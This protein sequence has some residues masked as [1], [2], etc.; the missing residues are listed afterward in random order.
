MIKIKKH[1]GFSELGKRANN[2]DNYGYIEASTYVVCDGVG[3]AEKGEIA[4]EI[5]LKTFLNEYKLEKFSSAQDVVLKA[6]KKLLEYINENNG[7]KGM[8]TTLTFLIIRP[9]EV[10]VAWVGDSRIY[11]FRNGEIVFKTRDHSWVNEAIDAGIINSEEAI[12]HPK[13]NIITRAIQGE[14]NPV[15]VDDY[16][17]TDVRSGDFFLLCTDGV[18]EAWADEDLSALFTKTQNLDEIENALKSECSK[19]SRDNHTGIIIQIETGIE[20]SEFQIKNTNSETPPIVEAIPIG[21]NEISNMFED[22]HIKN[23]KKR[24]LDKKLV[25]VLIFIIVIISI[26][27]IVYIKTDPFNKDTYP[28]NINKPNKERILN[29]FNESKKDTNNKDSSL[30]LNKI[31]E[32]DLNVSKNIQQEINETGTKK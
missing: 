26:A 12:N 7:S 20:S 23:G 16:S 13:S 27:S 31:K 9:E 8:A 18:M 32:K 24:L 15:K 17:I 1:S 28:D 10:Y 25:W 6:E 3:G 29:Q 22:Y 14:G 2:E 30:Q 5:V 19:Y 21:A 11:Q 4:S